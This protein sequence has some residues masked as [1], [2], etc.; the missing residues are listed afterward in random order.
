MTGTKRARFAG[1]DLLTA[2]GRV[3]T[4]RSTTERLVERAVALVGTAPA[5]VADVGSGSGA[6]AVALA[7]GAPRAEVW[8]VDLSPDAVELTRANATL[9]GVE[10]R[11]HA[12]QGNLLESVPGALDLIVAN[13]P[14]L[15]ARRRGESRYADLRAEPVAAVFA[16]GDGLGHYRRL[17][18]AAEERL[19][20]D[21]ALVLQYRGSV[22]ETRRD[23]L[24]G[25]LDELER[26]ALA[27]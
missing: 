7:L 10:E 17:L 4:P 20:A 19:S 15:P 16:P 21:G 2:P 23:D 25:L 8:A 12:V 22:F 6:I 5:R 3:M 14:Y 13:L 11:V 27:A 24:P 1:L 18:G 26:E 9:Y